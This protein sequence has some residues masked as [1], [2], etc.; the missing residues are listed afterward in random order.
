MGESVQTITK[1]ILL[2]HNLQDPTNHRKLQDDLC[3]YITQLSV[4]YQASKDKLH[5]KNLTQEKEL[6]ELRARIDKIAKTVR[7]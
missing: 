2:K 3:R 5:N 7:K 6:K 1:N 4:S